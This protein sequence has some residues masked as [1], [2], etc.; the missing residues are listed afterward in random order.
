MAAAAAK[1]NESA[2]ETSKE[3]AA[4]QAMPA[5]HTQLQAE[6]PDQAPDLATA[7]S[8]AQ[9]QAASDKGAPAMAAGD[10]LL[11]L[12]PATAPPNPGLPS[13]A[14]HHGELDASA[15]PARSMQFSLHE[16]FSAPKQAPAL[17][18]LVQPPLA[19][20]MREAAE[21]GRKLSAHKRS[22]LADALQDAALA[23]SQLHLALQS[24]SSILRS[25]PEAAAVTT[26]NTQVENSKAPHADAP[27]K[28]GQPDGSSMLML[29]AGDGKQAAVPPEVPG[30]AAAPALQPNASKK[31]SRLAN[32]SGPAAD[33]DCPAVPKKLKR[34][35]GATGTAAGAGL[36]KKA[37]RRARQ[38]TQQLL[39][40]K[41]MPEGV[42]R[43]LGQGEGQSGQPT[44]QQN[45]MSALKR[46]REDVQAWTAVS[47]CSAGDASEDGSSVEAVMGQAASDASEVAS[48]A[49]R[50]A[51]ADIMQ[52]RGRATENSTCTAPN[53]SDS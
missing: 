9:L 28:V 46:L 29:T 2:Q 34:S 38:A 20:V 37:A 43:N 21:F 14:D 32:E 45:A 50:A 42:V 47:T 1:A 7:A 5:S 52:I 48:K 25:E 3:L 8:S 33:A 51:K 26:N 53:V 16:H 13:K 31:R 10:D 17:N 30:R 4:G 41:C 19:S 36:S 27:S 11:S 23:A 49:Q 6:A 40:S 35:E 12:Q 39:A 15:A 44:E 18:G 22:Q 24:A